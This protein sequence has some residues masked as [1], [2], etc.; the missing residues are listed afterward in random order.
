MREAETIAALGGR[1]GPALLGRLVALA[2]NVLKLEG[3]ALFGS[4]DAFVTSHATAVT[5][6]KNRSSICDQ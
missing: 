1:S 3:C 5:A 2:G 6:M 4:H